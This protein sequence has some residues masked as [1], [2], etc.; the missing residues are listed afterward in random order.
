MNMTTSAETL[1]STMGSATWITELERI[2]A[3]SAHSLSR[4]IRDA[5]RQWFLLGTSRHVRRVLLGFVVYFLMLGAAS[6]QHDRV[7]P[8]SVHD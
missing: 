7:L 2:A 5:I 1:S 4:S 8:V 6:I 3:E